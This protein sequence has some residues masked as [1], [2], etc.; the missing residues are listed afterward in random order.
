[1]NLFIPIDE[2]LA[3]HLH[4]VTIQLLDDLDAAKVEN[5]T[6]AFFSD[7]V[8]SLFRELLNTVYQEEY[9]ENLHIP[10]IVYV[11][12]EAYYLRQA[13]LSDSVSENL[14]LQLSFIVKNFAVKRKGSWNKVLCPDWVLDIYKYNEQHKCKPVKNIAYDQLIK[15]VVPHKEWNE[16]GLDITDQ[17]VYNQLRSLCVAGNRGKFNSFVSFSLPCNVSSPFAKVYLLVVKMV[18]DWQWKYIDASPVSRIREV[19]GAESKRRKSMSNIADEVKAE[20]QI[21][22][23]VKPHWKSSVLLRWMSDDQSARIESIQFNALEFGVYLYNEMLLETIN[24]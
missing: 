12:M 18:K 19:L 3:E 21:A 6:D 15:S 13:L 7:S 4:E 10:H 1:M 9:G 8:S 24:D 20:V 22:E 5:Y 14:K 23:I 2:G 11:I 16:T 17:S